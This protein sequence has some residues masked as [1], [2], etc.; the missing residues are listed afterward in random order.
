[1]A[2]QKL[3]ERNIP[4]MNRGARFAEAEH[5]ENVGATL[6]KILRYFLREKAMV[7]SMLAIVLFGTLCGVYAPS[8][9]SRAI[10]ILAAPRPAGWR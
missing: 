5:A 3:E 8:L 1:M 9:Q 4:G 2:D 6:K 7:I 10:D